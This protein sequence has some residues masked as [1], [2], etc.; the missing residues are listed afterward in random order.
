MT[1]QIYPKNVHFTYAEVKDALDAH[2]EV[3]LISDP[4][5]LAT[6]TQAVKTV[7]TKITAANKV[8]D[9]KDP[10]VFVPRDPSATPKN[11]ATTTRFPLNVEFDIKA[12]KVTLTQGESRIVYDP[13]N[14]LVTCGA[15]SIST[16]ILNRVSRDWRKSLLGATEL[17]DGSPITSVWKYASYATAKADKVEAETDIMTQ[18]SLKGDRVNLTAFLTG[19]ALEPV[20]GSRRADWMTKYMPETEVSL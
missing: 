6:S 8:I 3:L 17:V 12:G 11:G 13:K 16:G 1:I 10:K 19:G 14:S 20:A 4:R 15:D 7:G 18:M 9:G 2:G 5:I